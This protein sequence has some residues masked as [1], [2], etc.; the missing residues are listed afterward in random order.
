MWQEIDERYRR[1]YTLI[2][3]LAL[4]IC[5]IIGYFIGIKILMLL[6]CN[7][8]SKGLTFIA[9]GLVPLYVM[10]VI[11]AYRGLS[12]KKSEKKSDSGK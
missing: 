5:F 8:D 11:V 2:V 10:S 1:R 7:L 3:F 9:L 12:K 4:P 6:N